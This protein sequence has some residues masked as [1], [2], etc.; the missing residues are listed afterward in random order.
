MRKITI[1]TPSSSI[2]LCNIYIL[3]MVVMIITVI[4]IRVSQETL[5]ATYILCQIEYDFIVLIWGI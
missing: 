4:I 5:S 1:F 3:M 2:I